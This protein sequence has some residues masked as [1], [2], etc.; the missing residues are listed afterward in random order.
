VKKT[1]DC[2]NVKE[3]IKPI[4]SKCNSVDVSLHLGN[5]NDFFIVDV[6]TT[7]L[8]IVVVRQKIVDT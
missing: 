3:P 8:K 5:C 2:T 6:R 7:P 1:V 4:T